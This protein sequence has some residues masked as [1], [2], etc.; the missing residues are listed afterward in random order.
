[1]A[2]SGQRFEPHLHPGSVAGLHCART[3]SS[4]MDMKRN[5]AL[6]SFLAASALF[7]GLAQVTLGAPPK[8][9]GT[10]PNPADAAP[11]PATKVEAVSDPKPPAV[12]DGWKVETVMMHPQINTPSV[13]CA[14]PDGRLLVAEDP[15]DNYGNNGP[16]DRII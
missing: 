5:V 14:L 4:M 6:C 16:G 9:S 8:S 10:T 15:M 12:I 13:V 2:F 1:M 7:A 3:G 11:P